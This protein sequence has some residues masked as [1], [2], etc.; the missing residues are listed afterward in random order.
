MVGLFEIDA[1]SIHRTIRA[2]SN[3]VNMLNEV[4][5]RQTV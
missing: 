5:S 3:K 1:T 2:D 4:F